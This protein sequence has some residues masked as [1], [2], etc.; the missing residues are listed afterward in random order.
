GTAEQ[1]DDVRL[2][3]SASPAAAPL[4]LSIKPLSDSAGVA[5][6][7]RA[8]I[9]AGHDTDFFQAA[10]Y[11]V[12]SHRVT[13]FVIGGMF[14]RVVANGNVGRLNG[15][16]LGPSTPCDQN[17]TV[18]DGLLTQVNNVVDPVTPDRPAGVGE[19]FPQVAA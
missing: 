8:P 12:S 10:A 17:D 7:E 2:D 14:G 11:G 18:N 3:Q 13:S 6:P 16:G 1:H 15:E 9:V 19:I 5:V 4:V